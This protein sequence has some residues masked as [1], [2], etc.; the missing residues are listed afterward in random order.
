[1]STQGTIPFSQFPADFAK[2]AQRMAKAVDTHIPRALGEM[3]VDGFRDSFDMQR[4]ND[5]GSQPWEQVKRRI[6]GSPWYGFALGTNNRMP[7]GARGGK[8]RP[9]SRG[10]RTN[11]STRATTRSILL[12]KGSSNLRDSIYVHS[13]RAGRIVIASDQP[14][15]EVH[16]EGKQARIF[17]RKTFKMPKRQFM[18]NSRHLLKVGSQLIE[19]EIKR[20][21]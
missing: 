4:F 7:M 14:H 6:P 11:F 17:G 19:K 18:G 16:N 8:G 15:A 9:G 5:A 3:L 1:M 21:L 2:K 13:A 20:I 10:G 12:G